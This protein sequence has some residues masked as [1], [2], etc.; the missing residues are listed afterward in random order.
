[1]LTGAPDPA[2]QVFAQ[3][4]RL[5]QQG[6][7]SQ[8]QQAYE[9]VLRMRPDHHEALHLL[10][11][12]AAQT[13]NPQ[14]AADLMDQAIRLKPDFVDAYINRG[15]T[16]QDMGQFA[17]ALRSYD[18][19]IALAANNAVVFNNRGNAL[20]A[21][22]QPAAAVASF[23]R[24]IAIKPDYAMAYT[25]RGHALAAQARYSEAVLSYDR[26]IAVNPDLAEAYFY[27]GNAFLQ[28]RDFDAALQTFDRMIALRPD[29]AEAHNNRATALRELGRYLEAVQSYDQA[30]ALRPAYAEA[31]YNRGNSLQC[32]RRY[33]EAIQAYDRAIAL[34][35]DYVEAIGNR[36][37][38]LH[39]LNQNV[40]AIA[41]YDRAI[42]LRG[43]YAEAYNNRGNALRDLKQYQAAIASY[44]QAIAL[45]PERA[46]AHY[47]RAVTLQDSDQHAAA[48]QGFERALALKPD[49]DYLLGL[50][51]HSRMQLCNWHDLRHWTTQVEAGVNL[52]KKVTTPFPLL[53]LSDDPELQSKAAAIV[54]A[55]RFSGL[56]AGIDIAKHPRRQRIRLGYYSADFHNHATAYLMAEL[57]E[58]HNRRRFELFAFSFGPERD[59]EMRRRLLSA[60]DHFID[61]RSKSDQEV[62]ALSREL[63][64]DVA[65]DLKGYTRDC[66]PGIFASRA[67]PIQV[68]Y[69]GYPGTTAARHIDYLIADPVLVPAGSRPAYS[70]RIVY[71]PDSYQPNDRR[72]M[73]SERRFTR[74][75]MSLPDQ[76]M[77][78]CSFNNTFKI[79]P[80]VFDVWAH[81][82][83]RVDGSVLWLLA[84]TAEAVR[85]LRSEAALRGLDPQRLIFADR[86]PLSDHLARHRLAD[87]FLD[88]FPCNAHT[89][90]SDALWAGL[91]LVTCAGRTFA[92]RVAASLLSAVALPDLVTESLQEY[93]ELAVALAKEPERLADLRRRLGE[94]QLNAPLFATER[95]ASHYQAAL[96][97]IYEHYQADHSPAD[98]HVPA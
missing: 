77:V 73:I 55:D 61:V 94:Q 7:L 75:E 35:P 40:A 64:I 60:F 36:G 88:T 76:G 95:F 4:V 2:R 47:N 52:G 27:R 84:D 63:Q 74:A 37:N 21:L 80:S 17:A 86:L 89:T 68:A 20:R 69:L 82:L 50:M 42:A 30:I 46:E 54:V 25:N 9:H 5:H 93:E 56:D 87:L 78:F 1:M 53:A 41:C 66:R 23:D 18:Q 34:R 62:A 14:R 39:E 43:D 97:A 44:D 32:L 91:P 26:A 72:R 38:A 3:G 16:F 85:N 22:G 15:N 19:A 10:G 13:G 45:R 83:R 11:V 59:D 8:A 48:I 96:E 58:R 98:I 79:T 70:E 51:L 92:S 28:I 65:L 24:A 67:A 33:D 31:H 49:Y 90:A 29:Y 71:L 6:H 12:I 81:I 57:F